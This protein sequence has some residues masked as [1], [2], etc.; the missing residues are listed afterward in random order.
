MLRKV[1][2]QNEVVEFIKNKASLTGINKLLFECLNANELRLVV[3][4]FESDYDGFTHNF[5]LKYPAAAATLYWKEEGVEKLVEMAIQKQKSKDVRIVAEILSYAV[6]GK[7][8]EL[9]FID[10]QSDAFKLVNFADASY[11]DENFKSKA[12]EQ[13]IKLMVNLEKDISFPQSVL[14]SVL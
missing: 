8:N 10:M 2:I 3:Q 14:N 13:L 1:S 11:Q 9:P 4:L 5:E 7:L 12:K 6:R